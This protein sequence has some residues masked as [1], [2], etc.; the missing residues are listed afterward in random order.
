MFVAVLTHDIGQRMHVILGVGMVQTPLQKY[1]GEE[2]KSK[3]RF[4]RFI[5]LDPKVGQAPMLFDVKVVFT[6]GHFLI[7]K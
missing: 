2:H 6:T 1:A 5:R 7:S 4:G 3:P